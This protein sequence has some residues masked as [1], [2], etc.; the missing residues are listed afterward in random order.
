MLS[1]LETMHKYFTNIL[2]FARC[3]ASSEELFFH[4]LSLYVCSLL[5][6]HLVFWVRTTLF[7]QAK[8]HKRDKC[9]TDDPA[10]LPYVVTVNLRQSLIY[11][12]FLLVDLL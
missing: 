7:F 10:E 12:F 6:I 9:K 2:I 3:T 1:I 8:Y 5:L 11:A 4:L